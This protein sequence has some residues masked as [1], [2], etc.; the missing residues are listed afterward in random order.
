VAG[1]LVLGAGISQ[2]RYDKRTHC[3]GSDQAATSPAAAS[4]LAL[5]RTLT[6]RGLGVVQ[7]LD[8]LRQ[9]YL[10][11]MDGMGDLEVRNIDLDMIG[12]IVRQTFHVQLMVGEVQQAAFLD[13]C[14]GALENDRH[15]DAQLS[16]SC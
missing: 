16:R 3:V 13:T 8:P 12:D 10:A 4:S 15:G 14:G 2:P 11:D 9:R 7:H 5:P 6:D 1:P